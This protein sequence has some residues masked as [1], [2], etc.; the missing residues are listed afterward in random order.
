MTYIRWSITT[1][2]TAPTVRSGNVTGCWKKNERSLR[3]CHGFVPRKQ[4]PARPVFVIEWVARKIAG[5]THPSRCH[6]LG[7]PLFEM[8]CRPQD[9]E[10]GVA[11][12]TSTLLLHFVRAQDIASIHDP[13]NLNVVQQNRQNIVWLNFPNSRRKEQL[14][15][16]VI[17]LVPIATVRIPR[18]WWTVFSS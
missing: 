14:P 11:S 16:D 12:T 6:T 10:V 1:S 4:V 3:D 7:A 13:L 17:H 15:E 18:L 5:R 8:S 2:C 9:S